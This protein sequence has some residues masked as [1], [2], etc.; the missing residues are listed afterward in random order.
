MTLGAIADEGEGVVL[1]VFLAQWLA[2]AALE[3]I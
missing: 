2:E 1:E 3:I